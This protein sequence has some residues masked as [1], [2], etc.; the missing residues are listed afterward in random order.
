[1]VIYSTDTNFLTERI[2]SHKQFSK[3]DINE[4]I[5]IAHDQKEEWKNILVKVGKQDIHVMNKRAF[6]R[7][8]PKLMET[9][10]G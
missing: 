2:N 10:S 1:M 9:L 6:E 5:I 4:W 7:V 3:N 8:I